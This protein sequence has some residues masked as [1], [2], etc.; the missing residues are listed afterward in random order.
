MKNKQIF[1]V[2][3]V[4][5]LAFYGLYLL[6]R[7]AKPIGNEV[8]V[9]KCQAGEIACSNNPKICFDPVANYIID[10]CGA[11]NDINQTA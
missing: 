10:P 9:N 1:I 6:M 2:A 11:I 7:T 8:V 3:G 5:A 4:S